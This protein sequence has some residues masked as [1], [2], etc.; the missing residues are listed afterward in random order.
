[1]PTTEIESR[2]ERLTEQRRS[3]PDAPGVYLFRDSRR[4]VLYVGKALSIR[5]RVAGHFGKPRA[6]V[7]CAP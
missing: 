1:M 6:Q 7:G 3:L 2:E 5:K 4:K